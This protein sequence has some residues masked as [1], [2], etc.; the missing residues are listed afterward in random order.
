M[1]IHQPNDLG[2][3][4]KEAEEKSS[5]IMEILGWE[6]RKDYW[7]KHE[8][9]GDVKS[10]VGVGPFVGEIIPIDVIA[11]MLKE[12]GWDYV[13]QENGYEGEY[14]G[15]WYSKENIDYEPDVKTC[16]RDDPFDWFG[17]ADSLIMDLEDNNET[18]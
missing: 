9:P 14:T 13:A 7:Y 4:N 10:W 2:D 3:R 8:I 1:N 6:R 15:G 17:A 16:D 11:K 5:R 12:R 18:S